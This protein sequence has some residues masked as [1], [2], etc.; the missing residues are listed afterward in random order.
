VLHTDDS[1][2]REIIF[3]AG[4]V[5]SVIHS[6]LIFTDISVMPD[7]NYKST[8]PILAFIIYLEGINA[9]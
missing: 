5:T 9:N 8:R 6:S 3:S 1:V 7:C 4:I 2:F